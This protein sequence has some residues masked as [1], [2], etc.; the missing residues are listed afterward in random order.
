[1]G[2]RITKINLNVKKQHYD[3][4]LASARDT[5]AQNLLTHMKTWQIITLKSDSWLFLAPL[6]TPWSSRVGSFPEGS[7]LVQKTTGL[8]FSLQSSWSVILISLAGMFPKPHQTLTE[9]FH[10][11]WVVTSSSSVLMNG[12]GI[13]IVFFMLWIQMNGK[14]IQHESLRHFD[15]SLCLFHVRFLIQAARS[16]SIWTSHP[17]ALCVSSYFPLS[18]PIYESSVSLSRLFS[19]FLPPL[20]RCVTSFLCVC[21]CSSKWPVLHNSS[22][23][24]LTH[25]TWLKATEAC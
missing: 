4:S 3:P 14:Y 9:S 22:S 5:E 17:S 23:Y 12:A 24:H 15:V 10:S 13:Y 2:K 11:R 18:L 6:A 21:Y 25:T 7:G 20:S 8:C 19:H 1:M 16:L